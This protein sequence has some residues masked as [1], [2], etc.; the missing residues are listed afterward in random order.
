MATKF[1]RNL[2]LWENNQYQSKYPPK[3]SFKHQSSRLS[4]IQYNVYRAKA[5]DIESKLKQERVKLWIRKHSKIWLEKSRESLI[6]RH[7]SVNTIIKCYRRHQWVKKINALIEIRGISKCN[8]IV[9]ASI[10][11]DYW[12]HQNTLSTSLLIKRY[13][14]HKQ[15]NAAIIIQRYFRSYL[16]FKKII[17]SEM[18][19]T[20]QLCPFT[21]ESMENIDR[22]GIIVY[23]MDNKIVKGCDMIANLEWFNKCDF[24]HKPTHIFTHEDITEI[25]YNQII[26]QSQTY[27]HLLNNWI[28]KLEQYDKNGINTI[29]NY[30]SK[31]TGQIKLL[32][33]K[34]A[35]LTK[36]LINLNQT[37]YYR[38]NPRIYV[39][40]LK[41]I[42][43]E[44]QKNIDCLLRNHPLIYQQVMD[45]RNKNDINILLQNSFTL[46][47][48][49]NI[50][51]L[52]KIQNI[53]LE[54]YKIQTDIDYIVDF[55]DLQTKTE[56]E[57]P[58]AP[59]NDNQSNDNDPKNIYYPSL[60]DY[61]V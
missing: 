17:Y 8:A 47:Q 34:Y 44:K 37:N 25:E 22:H 39:D 41:K 51:F 53:I 59:S 61:D 2:Q 16:A 1:R 14:E 28:N 33:T 60:I 20:G 32:Q 38:K 4:K 11:K 52:K 5:C 30:V 29:N 56:F 40:E 57:I 9:V 50:E 49:Y 48:C 19:I 26:K 15:C 42:L 35:T 54:C 24:M 36:L 58:S 10:I 45:N 6:V 21:H 7:R 18:E 23:K 55:C 12:G 46:N 31:Y 13:W 27:Q 3:P 43:L